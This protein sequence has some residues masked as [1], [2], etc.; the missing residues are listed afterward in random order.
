MTLLRV[1]KAIADATSRY[2]WRHPSVETGAGGQ[3]VDWDALLPNMEMHVL[4][5]VEDFLTAT[6]RLR[7]TL[8]LWR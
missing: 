3:A 8:I 1:K 2:S 4:H 6:L 7:A 5:D